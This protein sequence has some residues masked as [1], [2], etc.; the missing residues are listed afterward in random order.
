MLTC[1]NPNVLAVEEYGP[2]ACYGDR[3]DPSF[4]GPATSIIA[5][6]HPRPAVGGDFHVKRP[7]HERQIVLGVGTKS[8]DAL[9]LRARM[10]TR[11]CTCYAIP[12]LFVVDDIMKYRSLGN[13]S[14]SMGLIGA[15]PQGIVPIKMA[16][17]FIAID[18]D[19]TFEHDDVF[20]GVG[21]MRL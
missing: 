11:E 4:C 16:P 5:R 19:R 13:G 7:W 12:S 6:R 14:V 20:N 3:P 17:L 15:K 10:E 8:E 1:I 2:F 9:R 18:F 21:A